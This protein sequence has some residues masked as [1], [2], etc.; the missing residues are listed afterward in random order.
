MVIR[1]DC[2]SLYL[3][4]MNHNMLMGACCQA[5]MCIENEGEHA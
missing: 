4:T 1:Y 3:T 5:R 2:N